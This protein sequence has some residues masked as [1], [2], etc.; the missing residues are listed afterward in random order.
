MSV[1]AIPKDRTTKKIVNYDHFHDTLKTSS[2]LNITD[3]QTDLYNGK[4]EFVIRNRE[5]RVKVKPNFQ[6][7]LCYFYILLTIYW[8]DA[9]Q[10]TKN[11]V[12]Q[13]TTN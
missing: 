1:R 13:H 5:K 8:V 12:N 11:E 3:T 6:E 9:L 4:E 10:K 7:L 2:S